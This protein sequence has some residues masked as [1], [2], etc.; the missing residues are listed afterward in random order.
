MPWVK[1]DGTGSRLV[2]RV[3]PR[4]RTAGVDGVYGD[5]LKVRLR[6]PPVDG[7]ANAE[8]TALLAG[9]LGVPPSAVVI[10]GGRRART[11]RVTVRG[12][13]PGE[14]RRLLGGAGPPRGAAARRARS[15]V[16]HDVRGRSG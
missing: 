13:A 9:R 14:V 1:P 2:L 8:L 7:K 3:T 6:A 15:D 12:V 11:K 5:T 10:R 16:E 4:A